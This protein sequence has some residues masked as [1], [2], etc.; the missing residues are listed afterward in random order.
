MKYL[1]DFG[2]HEA[3]VC[4]SELNVQRYYGSLR[5]HSNNFSDPLAFPLAPPAG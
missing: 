3:E 1:A 2:C 5:L 4:R